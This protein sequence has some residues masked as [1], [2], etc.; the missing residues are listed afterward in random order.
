[1]PFDP[2]MTFQLRERNTASLEEM[3]SIAV[4][5]ETNL[6]IKRSKLKDKE[7]EQLK[8]SEAKLEILASAMEKMM[9]KINIKD[10]LVVQRHH[11]PLISEKDTVTVPKHFSAHPGYHGLNNDSFMY[12]I[13]NTVKDEAPSQ[14]VEE[15]PADMICMFNG[16]SSMDD[17][18]KCDQ[19]DDDHEAEIEVDCSEKP[20]ACHWQE[21]RSFTVQM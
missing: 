12:S 1:M 10:E 8:S 11:V 7:M 14:L 6:L 17:L 4:D 9:Q 2:E 5:V 21:G 3:Q 16:I 19:Y 20:T 13:H 18:P 15:Q